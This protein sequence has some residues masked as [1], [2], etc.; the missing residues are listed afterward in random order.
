MLVPTVVAETVPWVVMVLRDNAVT[1]PA[2][3]LFGV[4]AF[5]IRS[6]KLVS[7]PL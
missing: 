1:P 2:A 6:T 5:G 7:M 4:V 3:C